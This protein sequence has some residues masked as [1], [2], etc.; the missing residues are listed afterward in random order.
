MSWWGFQ[1]GQAAMML[2]VETS[3]DAAYKFSHPAGGP[4]VIGP[5]WRAS[6]GHLRYPRTVR[7]NFIPKG[8][9]VTMAKRYRKYVKDIDQF[10]SFWDKI[11]HNPKVAEL[12]RTAYVR[13][14]GLRNIK[15][16]GF[17][18]NATDLSA[19]YKLA[20]F[21]QRVQQLHQFKAR[22]IDRLYVCLTGWD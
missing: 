14:E 7:M 10:V 8:I 1:K 11:A 21:D 9:F 4:T 16:G 13:L 20:T 18:F 17:R 6:L 12:I 15:K 3:A 5:H 19:N 2:N 22:G